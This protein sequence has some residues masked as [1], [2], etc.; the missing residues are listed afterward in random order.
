VSV[1]F[2]GSSIAHAKGVEDSGMAIAASYGG[3]V[4]QSLRDEGYLA[5]AIDENRDD[6]LLNESQPASKLLNV[7]S[8]L[9]YLR[10]NGIDAIVPFKASYRLEQACHDL[11]FELLATSHKLTRQLE[12]KLQ[13]PEIAKEAGVRFPD[14]RQVQ[15]GDKLVTLAQN[16]AINFPRVFQPAIGF[17]GNGTRTVLDVDELRKVIEASPGEPG[18]LS[19]FIEG[20]TVCV[21]GVIVGGEVIVGPVA[22]QITGDPRLTPQPM[23][24]CGNDWATPLDAN[25]VTA[26]RAMAAR[27]G[28]LFATRG[29]RGVFGLDAVLTPCGD[30]VLIEC[31]PRW[32]AGL[33]F[34]IRLQQLAGAPTLLTAHLGEFGRATASEIAAVRDAWHLDASIPTMPKACSALRFHGVEATDL[35]SVPRTGTY[36]FDSDAEFLAGRC[37]HDELADNEFVVAASATIANA[38]SSGVVAVATCAAARDS[39]DSGHGVAEQLIS[40]FQ[41]VLA[42]CN[43][44]A[45]EPR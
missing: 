8:I 16:G 26:I 4:A 38:R 3:D 10:S 18:K 9:G 7:E 44:T 21:N 19:E 24:G 28:G 2:L 23:T 45:L 6:P 32:T 25:A 29:F 41:S 34:Q 37:R 27:I 35:A 43:P 13:L 20:D 39:K 1:A 22:R 42:E 31:N 14:T 15:L 33:S 11:G 36:A 17:A 30:V 12:N 40:Q 5:I